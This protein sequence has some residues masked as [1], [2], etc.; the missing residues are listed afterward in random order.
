MEFSSLDGRGGG[1]ALTEATCEE[2]RV[3]PSLKTEQ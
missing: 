3:G 1:L 2:V